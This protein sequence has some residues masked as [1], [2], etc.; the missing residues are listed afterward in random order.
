[1]KAD[2]PLSLLFQIQYEWQKQNPHKRIT[3]KIL[4]NH[5]E[6]LKNLLHK[7]SL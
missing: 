4:K 2:N 6:E 3:K 5:I 7:S 1:M